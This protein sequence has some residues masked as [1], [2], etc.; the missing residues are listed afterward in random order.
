MGIPKQIFCTNYHLK[1]KVQ[2]FKKKVQ[3]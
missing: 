3:K 2:N 1:K